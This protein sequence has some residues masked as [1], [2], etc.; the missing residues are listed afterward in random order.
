MKAFMAGIIRESAARRA[1]A[2]SIGTRNRFIRP[3]S[4]YNVAIFAILS[5]RGSE[6][7]GSDV[8]RV[9]NAA[10]DW[11]SAVRAKPRIGRGRFRLPTSANAS[12]WNLT[13]SIANCSSIWTGCPLGFRP[14]NPVWRF[15]FCGNCLLPEQ[16]GLALQ[17]SAIPEPA[18]AI[19]RR[20]KPAMT[21]AE[22][23]ERVGADGGKG[24]HPAHSRKRR[25]ALRQADF[26][27]RVLRASIETAHAGTG[28][29]LPR[30]PVGSLRAGVAPSEDD[31]VT[32]RAGE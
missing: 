10:A 14:P 28:T 15:G 17:A 27:R 26:R 21:L 3:P 2:S 32:R 1:P 29:G 16:A 11:H 25:T 8:G 23:T 31:T 19:Y 9:V 13:F 22:V 18:A 30:I 20:V 5:V 7:R 4:L 12:L 6:T 24:P